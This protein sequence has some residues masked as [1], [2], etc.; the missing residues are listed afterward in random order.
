MFPGQDAINRHVFW[1]DPVLQFLPGFKSE[2]LRIIGVTADIDDEHV[3]PQPTLTIYS[4]FNHGPMFNGRLFIHTS[5]NPYSLVTP[6]TQ[7][8]R[9]MSAEQ[10]VEKAAT[11]EDIRAEVLTPDRLNTVVF[12]I[13]A[14]VALTIA[15]VGVAGVLAFSVSARTREFGIRLAL[16]SPPQRLLA[17]VIAEGAV[18]AAFGLVAGSVGG[19]WLARIAE[20]YIP[21][22]RMPSA[23]PVVVSALVLLAAAVIAS[24]M[25]AARAARVDVMQALHSD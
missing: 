23:L 18:M 13:F 24:A 15:L 4:T 7:I 22:L 6:A 14:A 16:G 12:G 11:L 19:F 20:R 3:V 8:I 9:G 10:P 1:T 5:V 21:D 17:G 2:P 25:P